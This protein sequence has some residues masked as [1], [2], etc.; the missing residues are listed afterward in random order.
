MRSPSAAA[1]PEGTARCRRVLWLL[2]RAPRLGGARP[3]VLE[4]THGYLKGLESA[5]PCCSVLWVG[6]GTKAHNTYERADTHAHSFSRCVH[7]ASAALRAGKYA[8][9]AVG[10]NACPDG[11]ARIV[12][13]TACQ[14]AATAAGKNRP[15]SSD[16][17]DLA[18]KGCYSD[19]TSTSVFFNAHAIG[20]TDQI[21]INVLLCAGTGVPASLTRSRPRHPRTSRMPSLWV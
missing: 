3:R 4:G 15:S 12:D 7:C 21:Q 19:T 20:A 1:D 9:G 5:V 16:N 10:K 6:L 17:D 8:W 18:P 13:L 14:A 11:T 2:P